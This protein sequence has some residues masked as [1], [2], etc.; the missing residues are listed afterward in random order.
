MLSSDF[1]S[2]GTSTVRKTSRGP[3]VT[4]HPAMREVLALLDRVAPSSCTV[5]VT[6]ESGTGKELAIA[7]LHDAS[8]RANAPLIAVNCGAIPENLVESE[9]FGHAKGA[10][11]GAVN[12]RQ[13]FVAAAEG[14]TLFLDEIG[15]LSPAVQV[16]LLRLLQRREYTPVGE[17]RVIRSNVRIV[18]ATNRDLAREVEEGR[19]REDL[20]YRLNVIHVQLPALR[21]RREDI[22]HLAALFLDA[23]AERAHRPEIQGFSPEAMDRLLSNDWPGNIRDLE[24]AVERAVLLSPA[25]IVPAECIPIRRRARA[26]VVTTEAPAPLTS[27]VVPAMM[28]ASMIAPPPPAVTETPSNVVSM[29]PPSA[30]NEG[31]IDLRAAVE[32]YENN[33]I[34][35]A[36]ARAGNNKSRAAQLLGLQRTTLVEMIKRKRIEPLDRA[37]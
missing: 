6:G 1:S 21:D 28:P 15:E 9:L 14:G 27:M 30:P 17:T 22:P 31:I 23:A 8:P 11:T 33:L 29:A 10:F 20:Y 24:N 13:G 37:A 25:A 36:L 5:L 26:V 32:A 34:K 3:L 16:K 4:A 18:A 12:A 35:K 7:A 2:D 19:F